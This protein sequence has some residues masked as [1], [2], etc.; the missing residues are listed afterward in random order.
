MAQ[1]AQI[2]V[3]A[4]YHALAM[5][6]PDVTEADIEA[7]LLTATGFR[8]PSQRRT[9]V[10]WPLVKTPAPCITFKMNLFCWKGIWCSSMP[11]AN[12]SITH[13]MLPAPIR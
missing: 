6:S 7:E 8:G 2:S 4:H 13:R 12:C 1:A 5:I 11:A 3:A 9:Q 10:L